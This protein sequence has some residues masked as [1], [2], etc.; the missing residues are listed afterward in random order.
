MTDKQGIENYKF[1][2]SSFI[3]LPNVKSEAIAILKEELSRRDK[4]LAEVKVEFLNFI[5]MNS[6]GYVVTDNSRAKQAL[7]KIEKGAKNDS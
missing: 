3:V 4:L 2:T 1:D 7:A 6:A 5:R